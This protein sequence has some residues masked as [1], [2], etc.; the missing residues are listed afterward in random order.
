MMFCIQ[1][2]FESD[3]DCKAFKKI[4]EQKSNDPNLQEKNALIS[5]IKERS[6]QEKKEVISKP[7]TATQKKVLRIKVKS[8]AKGDPKLPKEYR[9]Y[10]RILVPE[11]EQLEIL[12]YFDCRMNLG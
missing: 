1:H 8:K 4:E 5:K 11:K 2:R 3:H 12:K 7:L 6:L 10:A 9:F